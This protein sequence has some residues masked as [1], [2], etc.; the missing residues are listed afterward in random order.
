MHDYESFARHYDDEYGDRDVDLPM[1]V[2]LARDAKDCLELGCGT[3]RCAIA[4]ARAGVDVVGIDRSPRMLDVGRAK[5]ARAGL[6]SRIDLRLGDMRHVSLDRRFDIVIVAFGSLLCLETRDEQRAAIACAT[7][8]LRLGG[9]LAIDV[10]N[11]S[12]GLPNPAD[13]GRLFVCCERTSSSGERVLHARSMEHRP[14][15]H[16]LLFRERF[17]VIDRAGDST[18]TKLDLPLLYLHAAELVAMIEGAGLVVEATFGDYDLG[19]L[20]SESERIV[21]VARRTRA[22]ALSA[23]DRRGS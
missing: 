19:P 23:S 7:R 18:T 15:E 17:R 2:R 14:N 11:P 20:R 21:V 1:Y 5:V 9:R 22:R 10:F 3:A 16:V 13:E 12:M 6:E 4:I 8:H